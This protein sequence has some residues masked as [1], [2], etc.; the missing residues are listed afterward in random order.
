MDERKHIRTHFVESHTPDQLASIS[1]TFFSDYHM[2]PCRYCNLPQKIYFQSHHL[3]NHYSKD[4]C[5]STR[6]NNILNSA[7]LTETFQTNPSIPN[8]WN[9]ALPWLAN[10]HM[11]PPPFHESGFSHTTGTTRAAAFATYC[12]V[13][14]LVISST[15]SL[16]DNFLSTNPHTPSYECLAFPFWK[17]LLLFEA[18]IFQPKSSSKA[19]SHNVIHRLKLLANGYVEELHAE[20]MARP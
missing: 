2:H 3:N 1:A 17:L 9:T 13:I 5:H 14:K 15:P 16:S 4:H 19:L 10:L 7:L 11:T 8:H 20:M 6:P 12:T 18:L